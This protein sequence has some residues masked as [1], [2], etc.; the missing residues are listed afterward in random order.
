MDVALVDDVLVDI[1]RCTHLLDEVAPAPAAELSGSA[2]IGD[3]VAAPED[4]GEEALVELGFGLDQVAHRRHHRSP[5]IESVNGVDPACTDLAAMVEERL[6]GARV[7]IAVHLAWAPELVGLRRTPLGDDLAHGE[8]DRIAHLDPGMVSA[9]AHWLS[10]PW[11]QA[12]TLR[13]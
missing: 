9:T 10:D 12:A 6:P 2:R 11:V 5:A 13:N 1:S 7:P 8:G 3:Q 4:V